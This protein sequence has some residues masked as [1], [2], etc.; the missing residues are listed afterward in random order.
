MD[1]EQPS[2][3]PEKSVLADVILQTVPKE[4]QIGSPIMNGFRK[5]IPKDITIATIDK[6]D[7]GV[8]NLAFDNDESNHEDLERKNNEINRSINVNN[9]RKTVVDNSAVD[10]KA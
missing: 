9:E 2:K 3:Q 5:E 8:E 6:K 4:A 7:N 1:V 10:G